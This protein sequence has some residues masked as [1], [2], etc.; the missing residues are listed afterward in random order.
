MMSKS[1]RRAV[2]AVV[3]AAVLGTTALSALAAVE[4]PERPWITQQP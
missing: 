4:E 3:L 1:M 2:V